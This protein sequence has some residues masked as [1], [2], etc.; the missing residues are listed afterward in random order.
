MTKENP[1]F[2]YTYSAAE[3]KEVQRI[4]QKYLPPETDRMEQLRRMDEQAAR[5]GRMMALALGTVGA[6]VLGVG[7]CCAMVWTQYFIP[8]IVIG[9]VGIAA[10]CAAYPAYA[11]VTK[12]RRQ[13][14]APQVM[15]LSA[16]L[17]GHE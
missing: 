3:Q 8:G 7:M 4:R 17:M 1:S 13:A 5:P 15:R 12:R 16:E 10:V 6:L 9:V 11:A 2:T 14:L